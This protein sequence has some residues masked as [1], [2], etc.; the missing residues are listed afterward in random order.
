MRRNALRNAII[1][2]C[3]FAVAVPAE[4]AVESPCDPEPRSPVE[5]RRPPAPMRGPVR[6]PKRPCS[7]CCTRS[8]H[9]PRV[10]EIFPLATPRDEPR[11]RLASWNRISQV[12]AAPQTLAPSRNR[13]PRGLVRIATEQPP[14]HAADFPGKTYL[15]SVIQI[16][17]D[18]ASSP[19][20][21]TTRTQYQCSPGPAWAFRNSNLTSAC[22]G[23]VL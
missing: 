21:C 20:A 1:P 2:G 4:S 5:E 11:G 19:S 8:W 6:E 17:L 16:G 7:R 10:R 14:L 9:W 13:K 3:P 23:S 22:P 15:P 18:Q 12:V